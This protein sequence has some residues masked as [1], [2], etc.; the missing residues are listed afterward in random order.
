MIA[1]SQ[2]ARRAGRPPSAFDRP[3]GRI[4]RALTVCAAASIPF[5]QHAAGQQVADYGVIHLDQG[6]SDRDRLQYYFAP[7]GSA[8]MSYDIFLALEQAG[9]D[10][11]FRADANL[12]RFGFAPYRADPVYNPDGLPIGIGKMSI[13]DGRWKGD[14]VGLTCA[15]CHNGRLTYRGATVG[16]AGGNNNALDIYGFLGGLDAALQAAQS[17]ET[18]FGRLSRRLA[19]ES[20]DEK[21]ALRVRL[22][23]DAAAIR[24]YL[25]VTAA[26]PA[27][28]GP[29][30]MDALGLIH[31]QVSARQLGVPQNWRPP[32]APTKPSF[33]WNV[34]QSAWAQWSGVLPD[35]ILRNVGEVLGVFARMDLVSDSPEEGRYDSTVDIEGQILSESLLRRLAPPPWPEEIFGTIDRDKAARGAA[36]FEENCASCHSRWPHRWSEPRKE[37]KR[38]IENAIVPV[39]WVGT[40]P[41][42]F[43]SAQFDFQP[44]ILPGPLGAEPGLAEPGGALVS[45]ALLFRE[46]ILQPVFTRALGKLKLS[47][48]AIRSAHGYGPFA[49]EPPLTIPALNAYKANPVEGMWSSPPFLHNGSVPSLYD[50]L[51][52]QKERP[53]RFSIGRDFDPVRVGVD[54]SGGPDSFVFDTSL[55]GNSNAGHSFE[56]GPRGAGIIGR[57]LTDDERWALIEFVKS[58]PSAPAQISPFGGPDNPIRAWT[59]KSFFHLVHPGTYAGAPSVDASS[60]S[61]D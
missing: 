36:L 21:N 59:D 8:A 52:P 55:T 35:P 45:P 22:A 24:H 48:D 3:T 49:P 12:A 23:A 60:E 51:S 20:D 29:G 27:A 16:I 41:N 46:R 13:P 1:P 56:D 7:Q 10:A 28:A 32:L 61:G 43:R 33:V 47:E 42:Q 58:A 18:K 38:F 57:S 53:G 15:A 39:T 37:G 54:V 30:R 31:N 2:P 25:T 26:P 44:T 9:E 40:D 11:P 17:D 50:L 6:W 14:W 4:V 19:A 5:P 34:P